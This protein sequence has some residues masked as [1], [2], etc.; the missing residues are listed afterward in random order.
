[1]SCV[2][3]EAAISGTRVVVLAVPDTATGTL[4]RQIAPQFYPAR[5]WSVRTQRRLSPTICPSA[6]II[7]HPVHPPIFSDE[8][9][10]FGTPPL[11]RDDWR[12]V[13][14]SEEIMASIRRLT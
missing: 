11:M 1:M 12:R 6:P 2:P 10:A 13:F 4:A 3:P 14:E 8:A 9:I 7:T 5:W